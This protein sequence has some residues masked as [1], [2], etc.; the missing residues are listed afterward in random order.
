[1]SNPIKVACHCPGTP[2]PKDEFYLADELPIEAGIAMAV[3]VTQAEGSNAAATLIGAALRNGAITAW[4]LVDDN[5]DALPING[6]T[7]GQR[8]TWL[9]GGVELFA[10]ALKR[11]INA[12]NVA[13]FG[14]QASPKR[15]VKPSPT[16]STNGSTSRRTPSSPRPPAPSE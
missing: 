5:G 14:L 16:G 4:N 6:L 13:P 8:V 10:E 9:K 2:H 7:V 1:M 11:Y 12:K 15:T 3:A